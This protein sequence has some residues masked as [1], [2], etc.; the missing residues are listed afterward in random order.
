MIERID[1]RDV[2]GRVT[3]YN[4]PINLDIQEFLESDWPVAEIKT[5]KYKNVLSAFSSYKAAVNRL[6]PDAVTVFSRSGR[7]FLA[8]K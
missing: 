7:L 8:R 5:E 1:P 4:N 6:A 2:P 3:S